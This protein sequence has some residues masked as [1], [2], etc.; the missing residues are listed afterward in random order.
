[1]TYQSSSSP[2]SRTTKSSPV[3]VK[4]EPFVSFV[5]THG[6]V[7]VSRY[8]LKESDLYFEREDSPD[9]NIL[10]LSSDG[11]E[12]KAILAVSRRLAS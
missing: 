3:K 2:Q 12:D 11:E 5:S 6:I 7:L 10:E 4:Q 8:L 1:M 9:D